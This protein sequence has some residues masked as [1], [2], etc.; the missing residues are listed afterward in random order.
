MLRSNSTLHRHTSYQHFSVTQSYSVL[1]LKL[2]Q[3]DLLAKNGMQTNRCRSQCLHFHTEET[4]YMQRSLNI[5]TRYSYP[6]IYSWLPAKLPGLSTD[7]NTISLESVSNFLWLV[8]PAFFS[9]RCQ[10]SPPGPAKPQTRV[11][12]T[13]TSVARLEYREQ[14]EISTTTLPKPAIPPGHSTPSV[15]CRRMEWCS[16]P[17]LLERDE[18]RRKALLLTHSHSLPPFSCTI[19]RCRF[20]SGTPLP[21]CDQ[22]KSESN[23][24][25]EIY[26]VKI[27]KG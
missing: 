8:W 13:R 21:L 5:N 7:K 16:Q 20:G 14:W 23:H 3:A 26:H 4:R 22:D 24:S 17:S 27:H 18:N 15:C 12:L 10:P 2:I 11:P 1:G 19:R 25:P 9:S 6:W